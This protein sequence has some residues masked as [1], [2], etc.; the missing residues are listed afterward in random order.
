MK[1]LMTISLPIPHH[2]FVIYNIYIYIWRGKER[3]EEG[4]LDKLKREGFSR[5]N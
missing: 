3:G 1:A 4:W 5:W 2:N